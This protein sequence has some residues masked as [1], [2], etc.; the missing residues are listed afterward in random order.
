MI[1]LDDYVAVDDDESTPIITLNF[2]LRISLKDQLATARNDLVGLSRQLQRDKKLRLTIVDHIVEW[3]EL[4][5]ALNC[6][7][8]EDKAPDKML[9]KAQSL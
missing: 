1:D 8:T 6:H 2:D 5:W 7:N 4:L 9:L 3:Q